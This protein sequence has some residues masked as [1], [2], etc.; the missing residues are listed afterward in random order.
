[1]AVIAG[2][3][4]E[5]EALHGTVLVAP[6]GMVNTWVVLLRM[7]RM[8]S[9]GDAVDVNA[10]TWLAKG[11][12]WHRIL[13]SVDLWTGDHGDKIMSSGDGVGLAGKMIN[14]LVGVL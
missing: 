12:Q 8:G 4:S 14:L 2:G 6:V 10:A 13:T 7:G 3:G 11:T 9:V 1:M 5:W